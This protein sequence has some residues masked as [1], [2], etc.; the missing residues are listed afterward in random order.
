MGQVRQAG[1]SPCTILIDLSL[2]YIVE[3]AID[4][5]LFQIEMLLG[6]LRLLH[7]RFEAVAQPVVEEEVVLLLGEEPNVE[8]FGGIAAQRLWLDEG[9]ADEH[10]PH[11][12]NGARQLGMDILAQVDV[13][14]ALVQLP[15]GELL[16]HGGRHQRSPLSC[17]R[18][19]SPMLPSSALACRASFDS[20]SSPYAD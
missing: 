20:E 11:P 14:P 12:V 17:T 2:S 5:R 6:K 8:A 13:V 4:D 7:L 18:P 19:A 9:V 3:T 1:I 15:L 16:D 10:V